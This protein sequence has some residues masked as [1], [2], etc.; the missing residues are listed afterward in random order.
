MRQI[1]GYSFSM[2][3]WQQPMLTN[4]NLTLGTILTSDSG[5]KLYPALTIK[6]AK[7][8]NYI[9]IVLEALCDYCKNLEH[10]IV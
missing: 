8:P 3:I 10:M 4:Q 7:L 1:L 9:I 2:D 5:S 6:E